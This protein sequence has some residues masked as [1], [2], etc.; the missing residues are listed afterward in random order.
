M[1][2]EIDK[3]EERILN[4]LKKKVHKGMQTDATSGNSISTLEKA[5]K[6]LHLKLLTK[7]ETNLQGGESSKNLE[8]IKEED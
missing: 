6:A 3:E 5:K 8:A 1:Q 7:Q 2:E 4:L